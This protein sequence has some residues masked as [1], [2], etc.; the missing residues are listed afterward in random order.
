MQFGMQSNRSTY[1]A[2]LLSSQLPQ[3]SMRSGVLGLL[4]ALFDSPGKSEA[5]LYVRSHSFPAENSLL[6]VLDTSGWV[7]HRPGATHENIGQV[8]SMS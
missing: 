7:Q 5:G 4:H 2:R 1:V 8:E 6:D 3:H